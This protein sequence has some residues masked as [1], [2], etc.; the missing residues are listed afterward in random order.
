[1]V[2]NPPDG[3]PRIVARLAYTDPV[4]AVAFLQQGFGFS[5]IAGARIG[6]D[7][8]FLL[9]EVAVIDSKIM[10]GRS[11]AHGLVSPTETGAYTQSLVVYIDNIDQHYRQAKSAGA[12]IVSEPQD[13]FWGD[14]RYETRDLEGHHW[15]FHE[16]LRDVSAEELAAHFERFSEQTG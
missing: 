2:R 16:H 7:N 5:E 10:I 14:R 12:E 9:T 1:M 8:D 15:S 3:S 6:G 11:G 13:Q 4:A